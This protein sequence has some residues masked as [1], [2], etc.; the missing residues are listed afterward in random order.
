MNFLNKLKNFDKDNISPATVKRVDKFV[1]DPTFTPS[2]VG[3]VSLAA[4]ALCQWV[5]S[6]VFQKAV[7]DDV[8]KRNNSSAVRN[9]H[10]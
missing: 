8:E 10:A 4:G 9:I 3:K 7:A 1:K 6:V 5:Q 2:A